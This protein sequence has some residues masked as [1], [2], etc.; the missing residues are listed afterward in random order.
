MYSPSPS[1]LRPLP[2]W[3]KRSKMRP[4]SSAEDLEDRVR[5]DPHRQAAV[6]L[7]PDRMVAVARLGLGGRLKDQLGGVRLDQLRAAGGVLDLAAVEA[8]GQQELLDQ[9]AQPASLAVAHLQHLL[10]F[11]GAE[12]RAAGQQPQHA[13]HGRQR[14]PQLMGDHREQVVLHPVG[15]LELAGHLLLLD[16]QLVLLAAQLLGL[17]AADVGADLAAQPQV[18]G[19]RRQPERQQQHADLP[20]GQHHHQDDRL[21]H[22]DLAE[23]QQQQPAGAERDALV[24]VHRHR[25]QHELDHHEHA[26]ADQDRR[27]RGGGG[28]PLAAERH[29]RRGGRRHADGVAA[30]VEGDHPRR[31]ALDQVEQQHG[32]ALEQDSISEAGVEQE[33]KGERAVDHHARAARA[34]QRDREEL[35][36]EQERGKRDDDG[37]FGLCAVDVDHGHER[38]EKNETD[39]PDNDLVRSEP[40][41]HPASLAGERFQSKHA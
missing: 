16:A 34:V 33:R 29:P 19:D 4:C 26:R 3:V 31:L 5:G 10:P 2:S 14:V 36:D 12:R 11:F 15:L 7:H 28:R 27:E 40:A 35:S 25:E 21:S 39:R 18:G 38:E 1:P 41:R 32:G 20:G 22:H 17:A 37:P 9:A 23:R 8:G 13:E 24:Q 6:A 30:D